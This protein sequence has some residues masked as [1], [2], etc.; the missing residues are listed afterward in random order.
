MS[1][2]IKDDE[3]KE[4]ARLYNDEGKEHFYNLLRDRY[5]I[6]NP[7]FVFQRM[8]SKADLAYNPE[9]DCFR[10]ES[11]PEEPDGIFMSMEELCS[12]M[13]PRHVMPDKE[14]ISASRP[15]AMEKLVRELIGDRLLELSRY[16][17]L[18]TLSKTMIIDK[19]SL[20]S[21]GYQLVTH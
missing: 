13:V 17:A 4:L 9:Q 6:K 11:R 2:R 14:Q 3:L 5:E 7:Y 12:P 10:I 1:K 18:D 21:D 20:E 19:T 16:V 15:E 8:K